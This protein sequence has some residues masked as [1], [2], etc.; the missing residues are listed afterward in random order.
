[1]L[2]LKDMKPL[3]THSKMGAT[4]NSLAILILL[5]CRVDIIYCTGEVSVPYNL[6]PRDR[7]CVTRVI[8]KYYIT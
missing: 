1:M 8:T 7:Y 3:K 5:Y 2:K 4:L 6:R